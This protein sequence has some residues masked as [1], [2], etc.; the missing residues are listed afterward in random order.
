[1]KTKITLLPVIV[2]FIISS[3]GVKKENEALKAQLEKVKTENEAFKN[4]SKKLENSI[5][6]YKKT[7]QEID[8]NLQ[9]INSDVKMTANLK[10]ELKTD[11]DVKT[12]ILNQIKSISLNMQNSKLKI[13]ALDASLNEL[14]KK[15]GNQSEDV[16]ALNRELKTAAQQLIEQEKEFNLMKSNLESDM[17]GLEEAYQEQLRI[18]QDLKE[19]LDRAFYYSG[20]SKDLKDKGIVEKEGG[21]IGIGRVKVLKANASESLFDKISK[22]KT[23]SLVFDSKSLKMITDHPADSYTLKESPEKM[24]LVITDK[25]SFWKNANYLVVQTAK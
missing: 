18:A 6:Q 5:E 21:F 19:I 12:K 20:T 24:V 23:D 11:K 9:L 16:L 13:Q 10:K 8:K 7:L 2:L 3:C 14:R 4:K 22:E 17:E 1:M 15:Y 25:K